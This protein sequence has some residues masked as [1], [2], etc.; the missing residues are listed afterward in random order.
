MNVFSAMSSVL[1]LYVLNLLLLLFLN[2]LS[3]P[4]LLLSP[5]SSLIYNEI[6]LYMVVY[7]EF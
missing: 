1:S 5:Y 3:P 4:P 2:L 7:N 6:M